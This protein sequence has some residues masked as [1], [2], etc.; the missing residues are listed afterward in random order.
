MACM[1]PQLVT[2][3]IEMIINNILYIRKLYPD[4]I[5]QRIHKY[6]LVL[7]RSIHPHLNEYILHCME[8]V[9]FLAKENKLSKVVICFNRPHQQFFEKLVLD[10]G[11][12][13]FT[14][15][16]SLLLS[17]EKSFRSFFIRL[18]AANGMMK[19]F[20]NDISFA[21]NIHAVEE[22]AVT[23]MEKSKLE[24][25]SWII[26]DRHNETPGSVILPLETINFDFAHMNIYIESY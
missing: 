26:V 1:V 6:G 15:S 17:L 9:L 3:F 22:S 5:F 13:K 10:V 25:F 24:D 20:P 12:L 11:W 14:D 8:A 21:I 7:Y 4:A 19:P 2:E 18:Y 23:Y 16:D